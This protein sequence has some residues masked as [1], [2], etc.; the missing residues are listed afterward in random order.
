MDINSLRDSVNRGESE[1]LEFKRS[2]AQLQRGSP[3]G[4]WWRKAVEV[5]DGVPERQR[6]AVAM[7]GLSLAPDQCTRARPSQ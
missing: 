3:R 2:T 7:Q 1:T 4:V 5:S 6:P